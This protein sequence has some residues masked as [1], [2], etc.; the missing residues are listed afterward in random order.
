MVCSRRLSVIPVA[1]DRTL[2]IDRSSG[3]WSLPVPIS[4]PLDGNATRIITNG[5]KSKSLLCAKSMLR[6]NSSS[7]WFAFGDLLR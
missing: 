2:T 4:R 1:K 7:V 6:S 3:I 5:T